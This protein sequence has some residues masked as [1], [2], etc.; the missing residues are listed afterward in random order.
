MSN[1]LIAN[2]SADERRILKRELEK[3]DGADEVDVPSL[4]DMELATYK[5]G[6]FAKTKAEA[7]RKSVEAEHKAYEAAS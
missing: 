1:E 7:R 5:Q 6:L 3:H 2:M 4:G